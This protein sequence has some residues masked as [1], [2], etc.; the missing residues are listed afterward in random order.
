MPLLVERPLL[1]G[2]AKRVNDFVYELWIVCRVYR[3]R[4]ADLKAHPHPVRSSSKWRVF[5]SRLRSAQ[6]AIDQKFGEETGLLA[7]IEERQQKLQ[8][9]LTVSSGDLWSSQ[10]FI[11]IP[12]RQGGANI[13]CAL[14][15][16]YL[17]AV[18]GCL[19]NV[20][21]SGLGVGEN[22]A[23]LRD[24]DDT[25]AAGIHIPLPRDVLRLFCSGLSATLQLTRIT[26]KKVRSAARAR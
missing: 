9:A 5:L 16:I 23:L 4:I 24:K 3:K 25:T 1:A 2:G 19:R 12:Y 10:I 11:L 7:N 8:H 17:F 21:R 20:R 18:S 22:S 14:S 15:G 13:H 26:L 6:A